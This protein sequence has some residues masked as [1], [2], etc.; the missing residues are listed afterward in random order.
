MNFRTKTSL[1]YGIWNHQNSKI[2]LSFS[3]TSKLLEFHF[4]V[5]VFSRWSYFT[6]VFVSLVDFKVVKMCIRSTD[7]VSRLL[8]RLEIEWRCKLYTTLLYYS[9]LLGRGCLDFILCPE[10]RNLSYL[11]DENIFCFFKFHFC[12]HF[13]REFFKIWRRKLNVNKVQIDT[14][15]FGQ[16]YFS[17]FSKSWISNFSYF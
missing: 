15:N 14:K 7:H 10:Q 12:L 5:S 8:K 9:F 16:K 3:D 13:S 17:P 6:L 4:F 11:S 1:Q 2:K